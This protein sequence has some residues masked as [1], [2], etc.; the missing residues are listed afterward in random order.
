MSTLRF[1]STPDIVIYSAWLEQNHCTTL[2]QI[3]LLRQQNTACWSW[4]TV[5]YTVM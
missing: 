3:T 2:S 5:R 1:T 4:Y